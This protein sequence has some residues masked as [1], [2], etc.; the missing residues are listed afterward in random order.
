MEKYFAYLEKLRESGETNMYG[1]VPFLQGRFVELQFD[2][3]RAAE[4]LDAWIGS[5][6][7]RGEDE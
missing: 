4:I 5:F 2:R 1:A 6:S 3:K 7:E